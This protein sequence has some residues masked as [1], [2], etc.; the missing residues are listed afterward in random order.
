MTEENRMPPFQ[1]LV[2]FMGNK[3]LKTITSYFRGPSIFKKFHQKRKC[4]FPG[5]IAVLFMKT[6]TASVHTGAKKHRE[7]ETTVKPRLP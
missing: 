1:F 3:K 4:V 2:S 6:K 7:M 5:N